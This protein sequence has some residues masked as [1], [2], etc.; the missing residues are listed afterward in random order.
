MFFE[1]AIILVFPA[2]M[3]FSAAMDLFTMTIPNR[4][5]IGLVAGFVCLAL[6]TG[7]GWDAIALH[8]GIGLAMLVIGI[9]M[10]AMGWIGGG[11]AKFFAATSLWMGLEYIYE[12]ALTAALL[13]GVLTIG[14]LVLRMYPLPAGLVSQSWL[15][16][17]HNA[18]EG[19][20]YG[21]ALAAS[22]LLVYPEIRW[23]QGL[24]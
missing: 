3:A 12:Y 13:G 23:I 21:I 10:F 11:D 1:F 6:L 15:V 9:G 2:L 8:F 16:R 5:S 19:V 20:P 14:M 7:L 24:I 22:G 4:I 17:L 18:G